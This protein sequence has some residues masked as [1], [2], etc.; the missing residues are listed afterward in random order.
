MKLFDRIK[1]QLDYSNSYTIKRALS[2]L[3]NEFSLAVQNKDEDYAREVIF[4]TQKLY[5]DFVELTSEPGFINKIWARKVKSFAAHLIS[6][7][8]MDFNTPDLEQQL[9][10]IISD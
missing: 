7:L 3:D 10:E 2:I 9:G 4:T 1:S 8:K 6:K 5:R